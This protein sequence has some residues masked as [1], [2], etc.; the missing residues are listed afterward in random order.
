M[1]TDLTLVEATN[2]ELKMSTRISEDDKQ[3]NSTQVEFTCNDKVAI[4]DV[5]LLSEGY[6]GSITG[7]RPFTKFNCSA[8]V[9]NG[10]GVSESTDIKVFPT[11]Q[12]GSLFLKV[13]TCNS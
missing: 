10:V 4:V 3:C 13:S 8:R 9:R 12:D 6:V 11:K 1:P 2:T 7:L 5:V